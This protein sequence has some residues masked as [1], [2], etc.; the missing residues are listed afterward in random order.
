M[1]VLVLFVGTQLAALVPALRIR[2]MRPV[3][4]RRAAE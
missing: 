4:A 3:E 1:G 2:K